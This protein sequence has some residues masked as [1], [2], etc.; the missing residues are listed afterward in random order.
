M[1]KQSCEETIVKNPGVD[2]RVKISMGAMIRTP[3]VD[4]IQGFMV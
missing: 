4:E 3:G 2:A 1:M